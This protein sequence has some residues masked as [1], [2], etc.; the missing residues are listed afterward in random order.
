MTESTVDWFIVREKYCSLAEKV[1]L[2]SQA[3]RALKLQDQYFKGNNKKN[4]GEDHYSRVVIGYV[5][6]N[7]FC[8]K[9]GV[10]HA[11]VAMVLLC[12]CSIY[13]GFQTFCY[14]L[15]RIGKIIT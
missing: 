6:D 7:Y 5:H 11:I 12:A 3:N 4:I 14:I 8:H 10:H 13:K 15:Y 1:W 9:H 2:I